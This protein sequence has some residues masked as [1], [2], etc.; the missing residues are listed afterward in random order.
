MCF[1][2]LS[3]FNNLNDLKPTILEISI[4]IHKIEEILSE[5][6]NNYDNKKIIENH[7]IVK[8]IFSNMRLISHILGDIDLKIQ[9]ILIKYNYMENTTLN[10]IREFF[11]EQNRYYISRNKI[12]NIICR[13]FNFQ[14]LIKA[15]KSKILLNK[16]I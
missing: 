2:Y 14:Y 4:I 3:K 9:D 11:Y 16:N 8:E 6:A 7:H 5:S 12:Y 10:K 1:N 13:K 15:I